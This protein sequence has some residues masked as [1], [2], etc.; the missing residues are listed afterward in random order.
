MNGEMI[1]Y[2]KIF[3]K[4]NIFLGVFMVRKRR[5]QVFYIDNLHKIRIQNTSKQQQKKK[6]K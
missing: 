5:A 3:I 4:S 1:G 6:R 2:L